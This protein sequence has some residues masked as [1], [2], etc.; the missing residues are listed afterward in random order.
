MLSNSLKQL[1]TRA[2]SQVHWIGVNS[3]FLGNYFQLWINTNLYFW[4]RDGVCWTVQPQ[5]GVTSSI[6]YLSHF[7]VS[8]VRPFPVEGG[9]VSVNK[10]LLSPA[11]CATPTAVAAD[12]WREGDC[13][14]NITFMF[15]YPQSL[16]NKINTQ[17]RAPLK[18]LCW[19]RGRSLISLIKDQLITIRIV[20]VMRGENKT[21]VLITYYFYLP[22]EPFAQLHYIFRFGSRTICKWT[23]VACLH[24]LQSWTSVTFHREPWPS[25]KCK[26]NI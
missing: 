17:N 2:L 7:H 6:S 16:H 26:F 20:G 1:A 9:S 11:K 10:I 22:L 4:S 24:L 18:L 13:V 3:A 12:K 14:F 19:C 8:A 25:G 23:R 5:K 15:V 21:F